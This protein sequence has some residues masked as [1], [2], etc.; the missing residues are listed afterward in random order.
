MKRLKTAKNRSKKSKFLNVE[1][2]ERREKERIKSG[3]LKTRTTFNTTQY[4]KNL[5]ELPNVTT[6]NST[7]SSIIRPYTSKSKNRNIK[8]YFNS[9]DL[10]L[11]SLTYNT[12]L[13]DSP[14]WNSQSSRNNSKYNYTDYITEDNKQIDL[15]LKDLKKFEMLSHRSNKSEPNRLIKIKTKQLNFD[16]DSLY[17]YIN[18]TRDLKLMKYKL[19]IKK[20]RTIRLKETYLNEQEKI[21]DIIN[22]IEKT[23]KLFNDAF[24]VKFNDYVKELEIKREIAKTENTNLLSEIIKQKNEIAQIESKIKKVEY[25]KN[26]IIRWI[27]FQ[28]SIK[29]KKL[30]LPKHYKTLIEET[31]ENIKKIFDEPSNFLNDGI[32]RTKKSRDSKR[33]FTR[34]ATRKS[35]SNLE[36]ANLSIKSQPPIGLYKNITLSEAQRI[37]NY[38]FNLI[39]PTPDDFFYAL[40]KFEK[41]TINFINQYND[42]RNEIMEL[43]KE[44]E[45]VEKEKEKEILSGI[46]IIKQKEFELKI[47]KNKLN[48]LNREIN[49]LKSNLSNPFNQKEKVKRKDTRKS[50]IEKSTIVIKKKLYD[51]ILTVYNTSTKI[52]LSEAINP[53]VLTIKKINT[54]EEEM[55]DML[56]KIEIIFDYLIGIMKNYSKEKDIYYE[57]YKRIY[58]T[59]E[60]NRKLEKTRKQREEAN[61]RLVKLRE[62][63][64]ERNK[65]IYFLPKRKVEN[66]Y[67]FM[68]KKDGK[69][70]KK[71]LNDKELDIEDFMDD[72]EDNNK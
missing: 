59:I 29:E 66:Y 71:E 22:S 28:I 36:K 30:Q 26:S 68:V 21:D 13:T 37:R 40:K 11:N 69:I 53:N 44:K 2:F 65:K 45:I 18:K 16:I 47:Q 17:D 14:Y 50:L 42:L 62:R 63:V 35:T 4:T 27:F 49:I 54:K 51:H 72:N 57:L 3:N 38:K 34:K 46:G 5:S 9:K 19:D 23:D 67:L 52:P 6:Q 7:F 70:K 31:D 1:L 43:K 8:N 60:R 24:N 33:N 10:N 39:Y 56:S 25:E 41:D 48:L 61:E 64:E 55:M 58:N 15:G 12:F 32:E 20:E